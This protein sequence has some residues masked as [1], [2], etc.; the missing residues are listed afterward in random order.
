M[1]R[2]DPVVFVVDDDESMREALSSLIRSV[3]LQVDT[4]GSAADWLARFPH[5]PAVPACLVL[6]VRMPGM[7][8]LDL[9]QQLVQRDFRVPTV[10][11]TGHGDIPMTVRAMKAG[12]VE[13]LPKPFRDQDLLDA[14]Q[15]SLAQARLAQQDRDQTTVLRARYA[16]LTAR[17]R[18]VL[19]LMVQGQRNKQ[20]ADRLGIGEGTIKVHRH[21]VMEKM[22]AKSL[23]VLVAMAQRLG[24]GIASGLPRAPSPNG[25]DI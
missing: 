22:R 16:L 17:E 20:A 24:L 7:N 25:G 19:A 14:I 18:Q 6:D 21:H 13:F 8:G 15:A 4:F 5:P 3:G 11:I 9:Q 10:F 12:A 23:P 2:T 1:N